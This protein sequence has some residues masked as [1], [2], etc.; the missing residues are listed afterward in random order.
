MTRVVEELV[1]FIH[2]SIPFIHM[3]SDSL[4]PSD[5]ITKHLSVTYTINNV[6]VNIHDIYIPPISSCPPD[7]TPNF[8]PLFNFRDNNM[9][10]GDSNTHSPL[11][12]SRTTSTIAE[13]KGSL[14]AE[15]LT[16]SDLLLLNLNSHTRISLVGTPT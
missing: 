14:I 9:I 7:F 5:S 15:F 16:N 3:P 11:W 6:P 4:F 8:H 12:Y 13:A 2:H 10:M 1:T